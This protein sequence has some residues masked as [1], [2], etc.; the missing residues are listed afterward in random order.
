MQQSERALLH[1]VHGIWKSGKQQQQ[2]CYAC[3]KHRKGLP[4]PCSSRAVTH[5]SGAVMW[6]VLPSVI[7]RFTTIIG[8][9]VAVGRLEKVFLPLP[10][11]VLRLRRKALNPQTKHLRSDFFCC[12]Y[13]V[14][15]L[16]LSSLWVCLGLALSAST[17]RWRH[18][19]QGE[20]RRCVYVRITYSTAVVRIGSRRCWVNTMTNLLPCPRKIA[21]S[22]RKSLR[23][24]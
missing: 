8:G 4:Y 1:S 13:V 10:F 16:L 21:T 15:F 12:C 5:A 14:L 18:L 9:W 20:A 22:N 2:G 24:I 11:K 3:A 19:V 17:R 6:W 7:L 23:T